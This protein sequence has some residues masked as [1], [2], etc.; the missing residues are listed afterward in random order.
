[1][2]RTEK[3]IA[4]LSEQTRQ[5]GDMLVQ[6]VQLVRTQEGRAAQVS[7]LTEEERRWVRMAIKK[8]A[9]AYEFRSAVISKSLGSLVWFMILAA[10]SS[11][12][13]LV[14]NYAEQH[15]WKS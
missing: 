15:G 1:M 14:K 3:A 2:E 7:D 9:Q 13:F 10:S 6:V 4:D 11:I 5:L 12:L 8:E